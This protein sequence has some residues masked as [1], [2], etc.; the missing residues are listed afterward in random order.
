MNGHIFHWISDH[1]KSS[2]KGGIHAEKNP[3]NQTTPKNQ[4]DHP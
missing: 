1:N 2:E 3:E 4:E